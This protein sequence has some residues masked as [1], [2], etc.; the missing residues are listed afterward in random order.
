[1]ENPT[2]NQLASLHS[3]CSFRKVS[4]NPKGLLTT[5]RTYNP[6]GSVPNTT[7]DRIHQEITAV[8]HRPEGMDSNISTLRAETTFIHTDI[9]GFQN[10]V[11]DQEHSVS[12][13]EDHLNTLPERDQELFFLCSRVIELEDKIHRDNVRFFGFQERVEGSNF[14]GFLKTT[15]LAL[16][17]LNFDPPLELQRA[18]R[19]SPL[20]QDKSSL[21]HPIIICFLHYEQARLLLTMAHSYGPYHCKGQEEARRAWCCGSG[22]EAALPRPARREHGGRVAPF[23]FPVGSPGGSRAV[24]PGLRWALGAGLLAGARPGGRRG[25]RFGR[26]PSEQ[27]ET[28]GARGSERAPPDMA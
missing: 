19:M 24:G 2:T 13:V 1:M 23:G 18:H 8:M 20:Q 12:V 6:T 28:R 7:M 10:S 25:F 9:A 15:L 27:Q 5:D 3:I 14:K 21:P 4:F 22:G 11:T 17:G 26:A 16:T